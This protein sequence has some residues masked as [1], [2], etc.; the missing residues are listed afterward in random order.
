MKRGTLRVLLIG[1]VSGACYMGMCFFSCGPTSPST[2]T[3]NPK[4]SDFILTM[5]GW[6]T[7]NNTTT[8][9]IYN[10]TIQDFTLTYK[11]SYFVDGGDWNY[12]QDS[13]I[14]AGKRVTTLDSGI[15]QKYIRS[16]PNDSDYA[17]SFVLDY[18]TAANALKVFGRMVPTYANPPVKI[19][20]YD[21]SVAVG[22]MSSERLWALA[23]FDK[24]YIEVHLVR[25]NQ[26]TTDDTLIARTNTFLTKYE[27]IIK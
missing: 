23:H 18:R 24:Y 12:I 15:Y 4:L 7:P 22:G 20:N 17:E 5:P 27:S 25:G 9:L 21:T 19:G 16:A 11:I 13:V 1:L 10:D 8:R 3:K 26:A 2:T 6:V 14:I